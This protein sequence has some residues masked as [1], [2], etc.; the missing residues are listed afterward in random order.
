[1]TG[2]VLTGHSAMDISIRNI[3]VPTDFSDTAKSAQ[4]YAM[5]IAERF[6]AT[7]HL[8]HV[9][10]LPM[11]S[12]RP[13]APWITLENEMRLCVELADQRLEQ[14][15]G[16]EWAAEHPVKHSSVMGFEVE[17]ILKYA[18]THDVDLI[19]MGTHGRKGLSHFLLGSVAERVVRMSTCPVLTVQPQ[20]DQDVRED[21][22]SQR[23]V[24]T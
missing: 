7:L 16:A 17:E 1:M 12:P 4:Q 20:A 23:A 13:A 11:A 8:L 19:V 18:R 21:V 6:G 5:S 14:E 10:P 24:S 9:V 2:G 22:T 3:L 15:V